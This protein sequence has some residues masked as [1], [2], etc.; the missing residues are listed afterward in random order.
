VRLTILY[1]ILKI[2]ESVD[3]TRK[4]PNGI[5]VLKKETLELRM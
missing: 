3:L 5:S 2:A 1:C 4:L